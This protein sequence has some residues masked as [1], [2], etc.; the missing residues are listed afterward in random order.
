MMAM[1]L[2]MPSTLH[3][4]YVI[5]TNYVVCFSNRNSDRR[6]DVIR[7]LQEFLSEKKSDDYGMLQ[8]SDSSRDPKT[9][10]KFSILSFLYFSSF[11]LDKKCEIRN[12][13]K[14][15]IHK[16]GDLELFVR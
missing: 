6:R 1:R 16:M 8:K 4:K 9:N 12:Y 7:I 15:G 10:S 11:Q 2:K 13:L 14:S 3:K 5:L